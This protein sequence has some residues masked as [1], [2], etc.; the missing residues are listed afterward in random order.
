[1]NTLETLEAHVRE[2]VREDGFDPMTDKS[3]LHELVS[4]T[5]E[6]YERMAILG[7][8]IP[9]TNPVSASR[10][11]MDAVG[12]LG[13]LQQYMDDPDVEEIWVN[14][15]E[16][17]FVARHGIPEL[18]PTVLTRDEIARLVE[19]M[20]GSTGRRLD[21]S[22]PFVDA[23]LPG[24][25][26]LHV[27][28][29]DITRRDMSVNIRKFVARAQRLSELVSRGSLTAQTAQFLE[30]SVR[31]G[32]NVVV[33][34]AT[35]AGKTTILRALAGAIPPKERIITVE[36]VFE[37]NLANRD[38]VAMQCRQANLEGY[39]EITMRRLVKES[40]RMRPDRIIVGEVREA[41]ALDLLI[42]L[43]SGLPGMATLHA[44]AARD[45]VAKLSTLPLLAGENVTAHFVN[46]AVASAIDLIVHLDR[47]VS[48]QRRVREICGLTGR[49]E[50]SRIE[51]SAIFKTVDGQ[52][53]RGE[54]Y[55]PK[56]EAYD[57]IGI[58]IHRLLET[59]VEWAS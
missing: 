33:S 6:Q 4:S 54:G 55:P 1:M 3:R 56:Q 22:T 51:M 59:S 39:G 15:P 11:L 24:G 35:G 58:S 31:A 16:H 25:E 57:R 44:N 38:V 36:E 48:G 41:E 7:K 46:P 2:L 29:P 19:T 52:L 21:L 40:L 30:A 13:K 45:A 17:V 20:L 12:G 47:D 34:G 42:A 8:V 32:L 23:M 10:F 49:V 18:T 28:I 43:N 37:L 50:E 53:V 14:S 26:R 27:V 9:L 5:I